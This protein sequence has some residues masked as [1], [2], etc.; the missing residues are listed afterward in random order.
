MRG[1]ADVCP[2][3]TSRRRRILG[4]LDAGI[5]RPGGAGRQTRH[6]R[7]VVLAFDGDLEFDPALFEVRRGGVPVPLEPQAL[8]VRAY[9][10]SHRDRV[11]SKAELMDGVWG[12]RFVSETAVT[13][14]IKQVR[15]ALGD[16]GSAQRLIRTVHGRGYRFIGDV[17]EVEKAEGADQQ[18]AGGPPPLPP[19]AESPVR[20]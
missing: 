10:S 9:L 20:Y 7:C 17:D 12:S 6:S 2:Q 16:D 4:G 13:S 19:E 14:R 18:V 5:A 1:Q 3:R 8:A 11:V 15:R